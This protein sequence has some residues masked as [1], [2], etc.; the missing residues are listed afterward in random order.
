M[1]RCVC[2][3]YG[4]MM[5]L[6]DYYLEGNWMYWDV[7]VVWIWMWKCFKC[8]FLYCLVLVWCVGLLLCVKM[9]GGYGLVV[10]CVREG[11]MYF[12]YVDEFGEY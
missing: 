6:Y 7:E 5:Y 3:G 1:F 8:G 4:G 9:L 11:S 12:E 10:R 2:V